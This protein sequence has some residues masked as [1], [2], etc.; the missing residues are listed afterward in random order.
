MTGAKVRRLRRVALAGML[1]LALCAYGIRVWRVH[2]D[3][4]RYPV[5]L[6]ALDEAVSLDGAFVD[7]MPPENAEGYSVTLHGVQVTDAAGYLACHGVGAAG[8]DAAA[9]AVP[10]I[11]L[12][13]EI[14]N[15]SDDGGDVSA[16]NVFGW[17]LFCDA[18]DSYYRVDTSLWSQVE[19][20]VS[21]GQAYVAV[22]P[23]T[24]YTVHVP[25]AA[26]I[27]TGDAR[28]DG[29]RPGP[30]ALSLTSIPTRKTIGFELAG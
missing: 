21:D 10:V 26:G 4:V 30:Y 11:D 22:H 29:V 8:L 23:H 5:E 14:T 25:F 28:V 9:A 6:Y 2:A 3:A 19:R 17:L 1:A 12:E 7:T 15:D 27:V 20:G 18:D 13:L 16:V 24:S